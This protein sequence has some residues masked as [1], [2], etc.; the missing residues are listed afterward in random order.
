[1]AVGQTYVLEDFQSMP[2]ASNPIINRYYYQQVG[3]DALGAPD[4]R[5]AFMLQV[6]PEI[7]DIQTVHITHTFMRIWTPDNVADFLET[8]YPAGLVGQAPGETL[9]AF[10]T[11]TFRL[12]RPFRSFG[13]GRKAYSG[14]SENAVVNG[15]PNSTF[16]IDLAEVATVLA[17]VIGLAASTS[18]FAPVLVK[19][20]NEPIPIREVGQI[21]NASFSRISTQNTRK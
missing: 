6:L 1:M 14:I 7:L 12:H 2:N 21:A 8:P 20:L 18:E 13:N 10:V 17:E 15:V 3:G 4:L 5:Q 9:P 11:A 16:L 19:N